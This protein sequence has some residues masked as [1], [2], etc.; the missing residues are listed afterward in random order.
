M[1]GLWAWLWSGFDAHGN[2]RQIDGAH[3]PYFT[4][5]Q[6]RA[7]LV[8][9][10]RFA[11][12]SDPLY[13]QVADLVETTPP[14]LAA[15]VGRELFCVAMVDESRRPLDFGNFAAKQDHAVDWAVRNKRRPKI[16]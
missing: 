5:E 9:R 3:E 11:A 12:V 14:P 4:G 1:D 7:K 15:A 8:E 10:L 2:G 6:A 16:W 13:G